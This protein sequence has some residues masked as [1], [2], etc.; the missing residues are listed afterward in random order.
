M[1][2]QESLWVK[3]KLDILKMGGQIYYTDTDSIVTNV[4]LP[5]DL[6]GDNIGQ[7][8]L[9]KTCDKGIFITSKSLY[10]RYTDPKTNKIVEDT[11]NKRG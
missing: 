6:V 5:A 9:E 8:K 10:T 1:P 7:F 3:I 11:K 4:P 2:T